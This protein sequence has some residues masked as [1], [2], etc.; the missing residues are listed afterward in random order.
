[1]L[2]GAHVT[3]GHVSGWVALSGVTPVAC[4][5]RKR[6]SA[7]GA[8]ALCF[9][10]RGRACPSVVPLVSQRCRLRGLR[11]GPS[12]QPLLLSVSR[13][14][15]DLHRP[16]WTCTPRRLPGRPHPSKGKVGV[17]HLGSR[18]PKSLEAASPR[19]LTAVLVFSPAW[20]CVPTSGSP[21]SV[22]PWPR[23][24]ACQGTL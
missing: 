19:L 8:R 9:R 5:T 20:P 16:P 14:C 11:P 7:P 2:P 22:G 13:V 17:T 3:H 6:L 24:P 4:H 15:L 12:A 10:H 18:G 21:C 23:T 1:M